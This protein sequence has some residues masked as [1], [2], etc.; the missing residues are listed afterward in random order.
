[1]ASDHTHELPRVDADRAERLRA[2]E[3]M[4]LPGQLAA[5]ERGDYAVAEWRALRGADE[6][7]EL[8]CGLSDRRQLDALR[9]RCF[10]LA[11]CCAFARRPPDRVCV[12]NGECA[13]RTVTTPAWCER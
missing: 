3:R 6:R 7:L 13:F 10:S 9:A 11:E 1:M 2:L 4:S 12:L 5:L 8:L